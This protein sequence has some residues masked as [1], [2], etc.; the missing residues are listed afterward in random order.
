[1]PTYIMLATLTPEGV[2]TVKNESAAR[3]GRSTR[4]SSSSARP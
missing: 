3:S 2:Q 1:M 4:R